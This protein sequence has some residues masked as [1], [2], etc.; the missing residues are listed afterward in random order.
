MSSTKEVDSRF[1]IQYDRSNKCVSLFI[2]NRFPIL[3]LA[4]KFGF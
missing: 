1:R 4:C 2:L 3:I